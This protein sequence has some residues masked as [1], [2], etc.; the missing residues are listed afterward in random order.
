MPLCRRILFLSFFFEVGHECRVN[1][2]TNDVGQKVNFEDAYW[3]ILFRAKAVVGMQLVT[4]WRWSIRLQ[5]EQSRHWISFDHLIV[6][7]RGTVPL[8]FWDVRA[9]LIQLPTGVWTASSIGLNKLSWHSDTRYNKYLNTFSIHLGCFG[10]IFVQL[11]IQRQQWE[12]ELLAGVLERSFVGSCT[13]TCTENSMQVVLVERPNRHCWPRAVWLRFYSVH[14]FITYKLLLRVCFRHPKG[15]PSIMHEYVSSINL[16]QLIGDLNSHHQAIRS[17][18]CSWLP[19][20]S[21]LSTATPDV[22]LCTH[23][24]DHL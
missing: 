11:P 10:R 18:F 15:K 7:T 8:C 14:E 12:N 1:I 4:S 23:P 6:S 17:Y 5:L 3:D 2:D 19:P 16:A 9:F 24:F 20:C 13:S 21:I 22:A